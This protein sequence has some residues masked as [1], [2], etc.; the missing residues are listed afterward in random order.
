MLMRLAPN[1]QHAFEV[2]DSAF[3][4]ARE[5]LK[6]RKAAEEEAVKHALGSSRR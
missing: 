3:T 1:I 4:K 5:T 2:S 6:A